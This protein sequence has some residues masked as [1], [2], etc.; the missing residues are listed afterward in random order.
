MIEGKMVFRD[1]KGYPKAVF[2]TNTGKWMTPEEAKVVI[3][4]DDFK[5]AAERAGTFVGGDGK[6]YNYSKIFDE[7]SFELLTDPAQIEKLEDG[8]WITIFNPSGEYTFWASKKEAADRAREGAT[9]VV[10]RGATMEERYRHLYGSD[11]LAMEIF[12]KEYQR[13]NKI[14]F[15]TYGDIGVP[16]NEIKV[17]YSPRVLIKVDKIPKIKDSEGKIGSPV[18]RQPEFFYSSFISPDGKTEGLLIY[19]DLI[20]DDFWLDKIIKVGADYLYT[21]NNLDDLERVLSDY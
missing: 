15:V 1:E 9:I 6:T 20:G 14:F 8:D 3:T 10:G 7:R 5:E 2:D 21:F 17:A 18:L 11:I 12:F 19:S 16:R 4:L 13:D